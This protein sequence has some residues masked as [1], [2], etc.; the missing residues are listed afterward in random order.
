MYQLSTVNELVLPQTKC[1]KFNSHL[2]EAKVQEANQIENAVQLLAKDKHGIE[3]IHQL[4]QTRANSYY[5]F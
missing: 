4:Y 2:E 3:K 5:G 1:S